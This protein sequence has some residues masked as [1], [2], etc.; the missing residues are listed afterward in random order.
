[1]VQSGTQVFFLWLLFQMKDSWWPIIAYQKKK[2]KGKIRYE[3]KHF[4][5][6]RTQ[7]LYF[8][9]LLHSVDFGY[10]NGSFVIGDGK[11]VFWLWK[12]RQSLSPPIF[13]FS[14]HIWH[15]KTTQE[16][17]NN[18]VPNIEKRLVLLQLYNNFN[19]KK[20]INWRATDSYS[21]VLQL[22]APRKQTSVS[23]ESAEF[24]LLFCNWIEGGSI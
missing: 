6:A 15:R 13:L 9:V 20:S 3:I 8:A 18:L 23:S 4:C 14:F 5:K 16:T 17:E 22:E 11:Q 1:M 24:S 19:K 2:K 10:P 12:L 21:W 7:K